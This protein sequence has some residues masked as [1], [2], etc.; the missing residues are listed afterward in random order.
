MF[1]AKDAIFASAAASVSPVNNSLRF[2]SSASAYLNR[3]FSVATSSTV[4]TL[5]MWAKRGVLGT[6][7]NLFGAS[8]TT[9][10]GFN[11][12]DQLVL[13]LT[14]T[15]AVTTTAVYRDPS[16]WYHI[17][18]AQNG[19][20]Q[21]L[22]VNG[23]SV[24][25]GTTANITFNTVTAHQIAAA[26]TTGY[27]DGY[28]A[29]INFIDGQSLTPS[30]FGFT[31]P[32][33]VWQPIVYGGSYGIN[34]FYLKFASFGTAAA[35]GNDSSGNANTWTVNNVSITAG[36]TY[37]PMLDVPTLTGAT[38]AN[39][40]T[41]NPLAKRWA[42]ATETFANG[43]L[44]VTNTSASGDYCFGTIGVTAGKWYW[45]VKITNGGSAAANQTVGV[46]GGLLQYATATDTVFYVAD[47]TKSV[48]GSGSAYG[49]SYTTN[50]VIGVALNKDTGTVTFYKN[51]TSQG[52]ITLPT[53][54]AMFAAS[55][56]GTSTGVQDYNFGQR[57]FTY[58]PPSGF[59]ALNAYNISA[60]TVTTSGSF[61]GTATANGPFVWLNGTPTAM[62][63]NGNGVTFGT[64][65]DKLA[66]GFKLRTSST[67]YN[68][69]GSNTYSVSTT[70][71]QFKYQIA[72]GNP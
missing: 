54:V 22:Y 20:A 12:S 47:G 33:N 5:S 23:T 2:R 31:G 9:S 68:S 26:N 4:Y 65:A 25:T 29:E 21:T 72:Q 13:V 48:A 14:G 35:L 61:T 7:Q 67:S 3:T 40:A 58:T 24:G 15:T 56:P 27:F 53:T 38:V 49:S 39:F 55:A 63:I 62:T 46:D 34:G 30:S 51:N 32:D 71:A 1:A 19:A 16:A 57:A 60:G 45:E 43:N 6:A 52:A 42:V 36:V 44:T 37:D 8:I 41:L 17:V 18:Y 10:L 50:D 11:S 59:V 28:L 69:T 64:Q 66:N 70:G